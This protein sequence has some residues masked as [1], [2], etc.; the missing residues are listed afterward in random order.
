MRP[1][2]PRLR[3]A[4]LAL[5]AVLGW[6][7]TI[8]ARAL[9]DA[10]SADWAWSW[11]WL[12]WTAGAAALASGWMDR[13]G[14]A[15]SPA[16]AA[17]AGSG[18]VLAGTLHLALLVFAAVRPGDRW[19]WVLLAAGGQLPLVALAEVAARRRRRTMARWHLAGRLYLAD[20][21]AGA[22][23]GALL[24]ARMLAWPATGRTLVLAALALLMLTALLGAR[25]SG[26]AP[27]RAQAVAGGSL[28]WAGAAAGGIA[29]VALACVGAG[30]AAQGVFGRHVVIGASLTAWQSPDGQV[31]V[32]P[33]AAEPA[34]SPELARLVRRLLRSRPGRWWVV[35][36]GRA[37]RI[38]DLGE[39]VRAAVYF[40]EAA[41]GRLPAL[42]GLGEPDDFA[43]CLN[44]Q[45]RLLDGVYLGGLAVDHAE[46]WCLYNAEVLARCLAQLSAGGLM[47]VHVSAGED[48]LDELLDVVRTFEAVSGG[49]QVAAVLGDDGAELLLVARR[50]GAGSS[51]RPVLSQ[52]PG[53]AV[54]RPALELLGG[55]GSPPRPLSVSA[56]R[57]RASGG[58]TLRELSQRLGGG[59]S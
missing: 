16:A 54:V 3:W 25:A 9:R 36:G 47:I 37:E 4:N 1:R 8:Q 17:A 49:A 6:G 24:A 40:P 12:A 5:W 19:L 23:G 39:G 7:L 13:R 48:A 29:A 22:A 41:M 14:E 28:R 50:R 10:L 35:L 56:P 30:R 34:P 15:T 11:L 44:V 59:G 21:A 45:T 52:E 42:K 46:A 33:R 18:A 58:V 31:G 51:S 55:S 27:R 2:P 26:A 43:R 38:G 57:R 20:A 53:A 32:L